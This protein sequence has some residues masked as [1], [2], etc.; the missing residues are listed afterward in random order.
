MT[1]L[2]A[3]I[4]AK[5]DQLNADD[6]IGGSITI[7]VTKVSLLAGE[8]PIAIGYA[9]D[10]GKPYKPCKSMRRVLVGAWG[11]D[12]SKYV[13]RRMTLYRDP[14][15]MWGGEKVGGIR[16]S[17]MSDIEGEVTL[18]LLASKKCKRPFTVRPLTGSAPATLPKIEQALRDV[19][20]QGVAALTQAWA[21]LSPQQQGILAAVKAQDIDQIARAADARAAQ[22]PG[23][24]RQMFADDAPPEPTGP[25]SYPD[26]VPGDGPYGS[27]Q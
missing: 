15:V 16:I 11:S 7:T 23:R 27:G 13:G 10:N 24:P 25:G 19:A 5:S 9:T 17:H 18:S 1:D 26:E 6:L 3:T 2:R 21:K 12:G 14:D 20:T 8:Q 22:E 4:V